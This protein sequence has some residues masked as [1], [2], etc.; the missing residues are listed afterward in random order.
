MAHA[1]TMRWLSGGSCSR[2]GRSRPAH[3]VPHGPSRQ[4]ETMCICHK[5]PPRGLWATVGSYP[6]DPE[7][8]SFTWRG[9]VGLGEGHIYTCPHNIIYTCPHNIHHSPSTCGGLSACADIVTSHAPLA[10]THV[11]SLNPLLMAH[12]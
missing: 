12:F 4:L 9:S 10:C 6:G 11:P 1:P 8:H 5:K 7:Q 3:P 2:D